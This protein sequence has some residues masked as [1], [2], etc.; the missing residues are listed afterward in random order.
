MKIRKK[1][2][3][4][5]KSGGNPIFWLFF[6]YFHFGTH[7]GTYFGFLFRAEGPKPILSL[8]LQSLLFSFSL[9]FFAF[10]VPLLFLCVF[11]FF[12]RIL[13]VPRREKPLLSFGVSLAFVEKSKGWR[14]RASRSV[15]LEPEMHSHLIVSGLACH[16]SNGGCSWGTLDGDGETRSWSRLRQMQKR[17]APNVF[18][19]QCSATPATVAATPPCSATPFQTQISV[20]HLRGQGGGGATPKCLGGVARH[21]CYTCKL[22]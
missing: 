3:K 2:P 11:P 7:F 9:L 4:N 19:A 17:R 15:S 6:S 22:L 21:R 10:R 18:V 14:V 1:L 13:G 5:R 8:T 12:P 20:R 16:G